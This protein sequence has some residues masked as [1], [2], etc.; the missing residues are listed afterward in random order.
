MI[1]PHSIKKKNHFF[2]IRKEAKEILL[3][4]NTI[5]LIVSLT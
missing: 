1:I 5:N 2:L 3:Q 4:Y